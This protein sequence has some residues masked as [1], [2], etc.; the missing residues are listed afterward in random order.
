M[1][2]IRDSK[3]KDNDMEFGI[4]SKGWGEELI[5]HN[6]IDYGG[7]ILRFK[8]GGRSSFHFHI[9][10]AESF[11]VNKGRFNL[12]YIDTSNANRHTVHLSE[13]M[14]IDI[15]PGTPHQLIS[16]DEGEI[17]EASTTH[18]DSD[19]YRIEKGDSQL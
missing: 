2:T 7:K 12:N 3:S 4:V 6:D 13:G 5:L 15:E 1:L 9:Q 19:S 8:Q 14:I 17:F 11:Y 18:Y 16:I 10:K